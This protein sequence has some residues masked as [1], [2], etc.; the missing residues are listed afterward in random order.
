MNDKELQDLQMFGNKIEKKP[1]ISKDKKTKNNHNHSK[2]IKSVAKYTFKEAIRFLRKK[3]PVITSKLL[4]I[5]KAAGRWVK[6]KT[7]SFVY[8]IRL[9]KRNR[10]VISQKSQIELKKGYMLVETCKQRRNKTIII[11]KRVLVPFEAQ[12]IE[13]GK[14]D[15]GALFYLTF[16]ADEKDQQGTRSEAYTQLKDSVWDFPVKPESNRKRK[17]D[18]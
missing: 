16:N 4:K 11:R 12:K 14:P 1:K 9:W 6:K 17:L 18:F 3:I 15:L 2:K 7:I 13:S 10:I 8:R 5:M